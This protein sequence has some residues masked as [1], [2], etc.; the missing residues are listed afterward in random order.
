MLDALWEGFPDFLR[1]EVA[2]GANPEK[3]E[4]FLPSVVG[5]MLREG[6]TS[7]R[8]LPCAEVWHGVTYREDLPAVREAVAALRREGIYP[9]KLWE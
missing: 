5:A 7:V 2:G 4:Y 8:V 3:A 9:E 6:K 1:K